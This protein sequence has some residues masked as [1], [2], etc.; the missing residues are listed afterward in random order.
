MIPNKDDIDINL[1][2]H[3]ILDNLPEVNVSVD[4]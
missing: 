4:I 1:G 2:F 3:S